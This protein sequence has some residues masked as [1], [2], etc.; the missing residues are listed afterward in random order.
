[1]SA[2][3]PPAVVEEM[4]SLIRPL[5]TAE[6]RARYRTGDFPRADR[7]NDLD[8]R[9]RWDL[10]WASGANR[11]AWP[12]PDIKDNHVDTA[13]RTIVPPLYAYVV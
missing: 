13:L 10:L 9:Y 1:M 8:R 7:V 12:M 6:R 3:I 11:I 4:A 2:K 5:D